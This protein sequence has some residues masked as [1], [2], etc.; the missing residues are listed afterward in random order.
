MG[1]EP[2]AKQQRLTPDRC[3]GRSEV[4]VHRAAGVSVD[5]DVFRMG[6]APCILAEPVAGNGHEPGPMRGRGAERRGVE[7]RD[8]HLDVD[9]VL[10]PQTWNRGR[11]DVVDTEGER[12]HGSFEPSDQPVCRSGPRVVR[13]REHRLA[14]PRRPPV[15]AQV[16]LERRQ[17]LLPQGGDV[18][19]QAAVGR[20]LE[21]HVDIRGAAVARADG[22]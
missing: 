15:H 4:D 12:S 2:V 8:G 6:H 18:L 3:G 13:R 19:H 17:P 21:H 10:R 5:G 7:G 11:P 14:G 1:A 20:P 16:R 9:E 22:E